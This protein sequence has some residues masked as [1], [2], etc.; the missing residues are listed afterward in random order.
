MVLPEIVF[1]WAMTNYL[2]ARKSSREIKAFLRNSED[3]DEKE[4]EWSITHSMYADIGGFAIKF[5]RQS[6]WSAN[7]EASGEWQQ[8][9][10]KFIQDNT[11]G[12]PCLGRY[13][14]NVHPQHLDVVKTLFDSGKFPMY[15]YDRWRTL[16]SMVGDVWVL[17]APQLLEARRCGIIDKLPIITQADILDKSK[18]DALV[19]T[20][21]LIQ[22]VW[23]AIQ[24]I[25]RASTKRQSS[26]IEITALAFAV[27][28]LVSYLL[29]LSQPKDVGGPT[30]L[31]SN[32]GWS[33][34]SSH[35]EA[36]ANKAVATGPWKRRDYSMPNFA[37][38]ADDGGGSFALGTSFGLLVFG[39]IHLIAWNFEFPSPTE[40]LLW[41]VSVLLV[42]L[43]PVSF[44][45]IMVLFLVLFDLAGFEEK[46]ADRGHDFNIWVHAILFTLPRLFLLVEAIR[47][48][49][50]LPPNSYTATWASNIP[51]LG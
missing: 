38:T 19:K 28:A 15:D 23:L 4:A 51:R 26:Q 14:W 11:Q 10:A 27:C 8:S 21:A 45:L 1:G 7:I 48:T 41:R 24:L 40:R 44:A 36:L 50:Y 29:L 6:N 13:D 32:K 47:S 18:D 25:I 30:I 20:L 17:S 39:A 42:A 35:F 2:S 5:P 37:I 12:H 49:Y 34:T 31:H 16:R 9:L 33:A 22:A 46:K 3:P 43:L